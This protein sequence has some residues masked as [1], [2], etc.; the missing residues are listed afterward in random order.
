MSIMITMATQRA[1]RIS[2]LI[3]YD[4]F[5]FSTLDPYAEAFDTKCYN[6]TNHMGFRL[7]SGLQSLVEHETAPCIFISKYY[8]NIYA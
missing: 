5:Y 6:R 7:C 4:S 2:Q 1:K 3:D 8:Y